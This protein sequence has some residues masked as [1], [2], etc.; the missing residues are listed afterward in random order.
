M[1]WEANI[2]QIRE[3]GEMNKTFVRWVSRVLIVCAA[4]LPL[5]AQSGL[6]GTGSVVSAA[7]GQAAR[8]ALRAFVERADAASKLQAFGLTPQQ[9]RERIAALT[10]REAAALAARAG[11]AP[12][13]A[14]GAGF[15]ILL[16]LIF[17]LWRFVLDPHFN[18]DTKKDDK[19]K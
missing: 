6:V 11:H 8:D 17:L 4:F 14:D 12:A 19:K 10:D 1:G 2:S 13:G 7:E 9:A 5:Q 15:G 16:V 18:P 3:G